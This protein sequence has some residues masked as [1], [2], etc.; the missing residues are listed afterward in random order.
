MKRSGFYQWR[1]VPRSNSM[2]LRMTLWIELGHLSILHQFEKGCMIFYI[3]QPL[4]E[5]HHSRFAASQLFK[6]NA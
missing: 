1:Q 6:N 2:V 4:L 5:G 3:Q